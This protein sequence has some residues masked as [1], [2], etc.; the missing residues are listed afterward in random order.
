MPI[1]RNACT[2]RSTIEF[3]AGSFDATYILRVS[4][5]DRETEKETEKQHE[6]GEWEGAKDEREKEL[7][8]LS[9]GERGS[10]KQN[11]E[12]LLRADQPT[13]AS[14]ASSSLFW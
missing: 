2:K 4:E 6:K 9:E 8:T 12:A 3:R 11:C 7:N 14:S 5:M 1:R 13:T 10:R